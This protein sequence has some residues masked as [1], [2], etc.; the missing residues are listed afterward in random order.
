M[1]VIASTVTGAEAVPSGAESLWGIANNRLFFANWADEIEVT[2]TWPVNIGT[3]S[4]SAE[5]R[6][7]Q[8]SKPNRILRFTITAT[9]AQESWLL[10]NLL[11][12]TGICRSLVPLYC[13]YTR[14]TAANSGAVLTCDTTYRR[15]FV[16]AKVALAIPVN[17]GVAYQVFEGKTIGSL[18]SGSI[19]LTTSPSVTYPI[20]SRVIPLLECDVIPESTAT[21]IGGGKL[22]ANVIATEIPGDA[23][24]PPLASIGDT[25]AY[26]TFS[27]YPIF[28][29]GLNRNVGWRATEDGWKRDNIIT[30]M[31]QG[32]IYE[33][34]GPRPRAHSPREVIATTRADAW[35]IL[36]FW[37]YCR[38]STYPFFALDPF[39]L[40]DLRA[41][42]TTTLQVTASG[43]LE[44]WSY[45][46]YIAVVKRQ[47][48]SGAARVRAIS[49]VTRSSGV[50][51]INLATAL[52]SMTLAQVAYVA[53]ASLMRFESQDMTEKWKSSQ[54]LSLSFNLV[55][56]LN[57]ASVVLT[58]L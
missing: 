7:V 40:F 20:G 47:T 6:S 57:E 18:T 19:T 56:V 35:N 34:F 9:K 3:G 32:R 31:G 41:I 26:G 14:M 53:P 17:G 54:N 23:A 10:K 27:G 5:K 15:F 30:S 52:D 28:D 16:G 25:I 29:P 42:T 50:D 38:G 11:L 12:R 1:S 36:Q 13:D 21:N 37:D 2:S 8:G 55:E 58:N 24:F 44:D 51:T 49:S 46:P 4:S 22:S 43:P 33:L 45:Y 39:P 48:D